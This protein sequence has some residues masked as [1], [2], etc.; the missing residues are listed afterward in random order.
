MV[1]ITEFG[2]TAHVNGN[3]GTDHGTGSSAL[4]AGGALKPGGI[5]GDWPTLARPKLFENRD[6]APTM[7]MRSLLKGVLAEHLAVD[8]AALD[9][10]V[11][12]DSA[13]ARPAASLI[14]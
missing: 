13:Q 10:A 3:S 14:A 2:R 5:V 1:A 4:L 11:F 8:R 7:D 12:P 6:V 9:A